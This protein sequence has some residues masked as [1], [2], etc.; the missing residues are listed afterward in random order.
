MMTT[1]EF[2]KSLKPYAILLDRQTF[3]TIRGQGLRGDIEGAR[4]GIR[5]AMRKYEKS[6]RKQIFNVAH[7]NTR[8]KKWNDKRPYR[9]VFRE[10]LREA[11]V[12]MKIYRETESEVASTTES[13]DSQRRRKQSENR[14]AQDFQAGRITE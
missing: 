3:K 12:V 11:Y 8:R 13:V 9:E 10:S 1:R 4:K 5:T 6:P 7:R 2:V 14:H